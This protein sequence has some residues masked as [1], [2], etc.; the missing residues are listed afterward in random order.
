[1]ALN[2]SKYFLKLFR[3]LIVAVDN[4]ASPGINVVGNSG[5]DP[6]RVY[7]LA[8]L[9]DTSD[10]T[11]EVRHHNG[12]TSAMIWTGNLLTSAGAS[13]SNPA[14]DLIKENR[15]AGLELDDRGN[16][17]FDL[18][19]GH[20]IRVRSTAA[21]TVSITALALVRDFAA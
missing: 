5:T 16:Y 20:S 19:N 21:P 8:L 17:F 12:T 10:R 7:S 3:R 13:E 9:G 14:P 11:I 6:S 15:L 2:T 1:M 4:T 18:P